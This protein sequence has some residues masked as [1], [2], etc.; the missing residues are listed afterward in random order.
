MLSQCAT[1]AIQACLRVQGFESIDR[2]F[3]PYFHTQDSSQQQKTATE[4][5]EKKV[6]RFIGELVQHRIRCESEQR[7]ENEKMAF[8][9]DQF[10]VKLKNQLSI[11]DKTIEEVQSNLMI[12]QNVKAV[13]ELE[14]EIN[15][16]KI[17]KT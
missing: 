11:I 4:K 9:R 12:L 3:V 6:L 17:K 7:A 15:T 14:N 16:L 5:F 1:S 13:E 2:L 10:E 8:F